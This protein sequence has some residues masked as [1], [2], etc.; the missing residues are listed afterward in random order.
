ME[1]SLWNH[2]Y[3]IATNSYHPKCKMQCACANRVSMRKYRVR[4]PKI[5]SRL[6]II[7]SFLLRA[8]IIIYIALTS[9]SEKNILLIYGYLTCIFKEP[10]AC[11]LDGHTNTR[12]IEFMRASVCEKTYFEPAAML[13]FNLSLQLI[14]GGHHLPPPRPSRYIFR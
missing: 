1:G 5:D 6:R 2:T 13:R 11:P 4:M 7:R 14:M 12:T 10:N 3:I 9:A 8:N